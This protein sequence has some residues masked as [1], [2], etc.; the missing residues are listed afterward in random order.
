[1]VHGCFLYLSEHYLRHFPT[2]DED[3]F[4]YGEEDIISYNCI[5]KQLR[6]AYDPL[7][8]VRHGDAKSTSTG[9]NFR[10]KTLSKSLSTLRA[11]I[12]FTGLV[13]EYIRTRQH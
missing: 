10:G 3:L 7:T 9:N 2:L 5:Q 1:M 8:S 6:V 4:M 12:V 13:H 11:K